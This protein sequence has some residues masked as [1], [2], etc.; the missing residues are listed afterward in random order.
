M[1]NILV[2]TEQFND[3]GEWSQNDFLTVNADTDAAPVFAGQLANPA[4][5]LI[6]NNVTNVCNLTSGFKTITSDGSDWLMSLFIKKDSITTR[7]ASLYIDMQNGTRVEAFANIDTKNGLIT[8]VSGLPTFDAVGVVD[9]DSIWWRFWARKANNNTGNNAIRVG[10]FSAQTSSFGGG[11]D[12][13][14]IGNIT[15]WGA[16][17][18]NTS[19]L[20]NYEPDPTYLFIPFSNPFFTTVGA[21]RMI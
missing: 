1:A 11:A 21:K 14:A 20:Q 2:K 13:S 3:A 4:D 17:L 7:F 6:D 5:T 8:T 10:F 12:N 19:T 18:T 15:A 16:N 9:V